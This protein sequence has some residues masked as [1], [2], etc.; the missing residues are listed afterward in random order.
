M[1]MLG[2]F[3]PPGPYKEDC[4][5]VMGFDHTNMLPPR[6]PIKQ[7]RPEASKLEA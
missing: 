6:T 4:R 2:G 7:R 3:M 1:A 5:N